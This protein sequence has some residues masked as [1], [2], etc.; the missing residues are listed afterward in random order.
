M[1]GSSRPDVMSLIMLRPLAVVLLAAG[2]WTIRPEHWRTSPFVAAMAAA[3]VGLTLLHLLPLPPALWSLAPGR[4]LIAEVDRAAGLGSVWRP[5]SMAPWLTWNAFFSLAIPLAVLVHGLQLTRHEL[6]TLMLLMLAAGGVTVVWGAMQMLAD[7]DASLYLYRQSNRGAGVGLFANRNH[8]A[9]Y[10]SAML[11]M[12]AV[13]VAGNDGF[14]HHRERSLVLLFLTAA[15]LVTMLLLLGSRAGLVCGVIGLAA[16]A[17]I[18]GLRLAG[19]KRRLR[20]LWPAAIGGFAVL[21]ALSVLAF[22]TGQAA[23][24]QHALD[25]ADATGGGD[26]RF[27]VWPVAWNVARLLAPLGSGI[28]TYQTVVQIF[29]PAAMLRSTYSNHA[30]ND[31]LEVTMTAGLA[32]VLLLL[33]AMTGYARACWAAWR[34]RLR[35]EGLL[36]WAGLIVIF[37][38]AVASMVD[39]PLR[40]PIISCLFVLACLWARAG[41]GAGR[42]EG[43]GEPP[44]A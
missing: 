26:L 17:A 4:E 11:P 25:T 33:V 3:V 37:L 28:G 35:A 41:I 19:L 23:S 5:L 40:T 20:W 15:V 38:C 6:R 2:L 44:V 8:Q 10:L 7:P 13:A 34:N 9:L 32:G 12:S 36:A 31:W 14:A 24:V 16:M 29:E 39:Y 27:S 21:A 22:V 18:V 1:G 43:N 42:P 30:H